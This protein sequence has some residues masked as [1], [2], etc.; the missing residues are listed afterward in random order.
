MTHGEAAHERGT[1]NMFTGYRP[2]PGA[3]VSLA[4]A[5]VV[6]HELGSRNNLPPYVCI[7]SVPNEFAGTGYLSLGLLARSA[8]AAIRP[9]DGFKVRD[10]NMHDG[11]TTDRFDRRRDILDTVDEHFRTLEKSDALSAMD[12]FYQSR[13]RAGLF[14]ESA[15]SLQPRR[16]AGEDPRRIR[17]NTTPA[18]A[19]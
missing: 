12:S 5:R 14:A 17:Q 8:S 11:I 4:W 13:L 6:S 15:R 9:T 2:S 3:P 1:H 19:C 10:L 7:P 16:R 18:S